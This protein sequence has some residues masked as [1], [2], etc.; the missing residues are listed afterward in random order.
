MYWVLLHFCAEI[1][2]RRNLWGEKCIWTCGCRWISVRHSR[3]IREVWLY[4][5]WQEYEAKQ[6][7]I[8]SKLKTENSKNWVC[9]CG[10]GCSSMYSKSFLFQSKLNQA[11]PPKHFTAP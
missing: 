3:E 2:D 1:L 10:G 11:L 5:W 7:F 8:A 9:V 4:S 6:L